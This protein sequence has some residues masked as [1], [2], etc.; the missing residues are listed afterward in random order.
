MDNNLTPVEEA[1]PGIRD[2]VT[3]F[4]NSCGQF[5][6]S[7][8]IRLLGAIL[9]LFIGCKLIR[10]IVKRVNKGKKFQTFPANVKVLIIDLVKVALYVLLI[11]T[12]AAML[13][14]EMT[15]I[16]AVIASAGLAIGL[17]L[18]GSLSNFAGG[19]MILVFHPFEIGDFISDGANSGTV[20][21]IGIFYTTLL[22]P[23]NKIIT[24]PNGTLSN[25]AVTDFS[26][27]ETR[28]LDLSIGVSYDADIDKVKE[29]L[30]AVAAEHPLVL[31]DPAP[32]VLLGE[33]A[34][35]ALV[36][37]V[38]VWVNNADYWTANF[39][40]MEKTKH[41]LDENGISIP[42]PQLDVHLEK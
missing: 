32:V 33:H 21:D 39:D 23:D 22:T 3:T 29:V 42:F 4:L 7:A 16:A 13:G 35:S 40:L 2:T 10:W 41:A 19:I 8:G 38:R 15:S 31:K 14:V 12:V 36:F 25:S 17:A 37:Y 24:I 9:V 20:T 5:L 1:A 30:T 26:A 34:Q 18:Q 27:K 11:V 6:A 28:R